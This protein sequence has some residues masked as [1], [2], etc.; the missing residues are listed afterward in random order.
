[1]LGVNA[2]LLHEIR[3]WFTVLCASL[4]LSELTV[5]S[6]MG[7]CGGTP[8]SSGKSYMYSV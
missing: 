2:R 8:F 7:F 6:E 3:P 5:L 4:T 1:M